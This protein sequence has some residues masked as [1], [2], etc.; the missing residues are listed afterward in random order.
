MSICSSI[1]QSNP[2]NKMVGDSICVSIVV[3]D[4]LVI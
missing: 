3:N 4:F 1:G 2:K